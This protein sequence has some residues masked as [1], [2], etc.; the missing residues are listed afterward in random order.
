[1]QREISNKIRLGENLNPLRDVSNV[2]SIDKVANLRDVFGKVDKLGALWDY[3]EADASL[4]RYIP[5]LTDVSRQG[6]L[7]SINAKKH[8]QHKLTLTKKH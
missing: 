8:M 3:G 7:Y 4:A 6:Q 5:D 2:P 1:M